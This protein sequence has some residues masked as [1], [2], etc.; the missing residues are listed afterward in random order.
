LHKWYNENDQIQKY[1]QYAYKISNWNLDFVATL[2]AEN[3]LRDP[4]R[5]AMIKSED[6]RWFCQLHRSWHKDVVDDP[7][8]WS[9]PY[10]Q[11]EQCWNKYKGWTKFYWYYQ[12]N[13]VK[14]RF[15]I[16]K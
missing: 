13:K 10:W 15:L 14:W 12:R 3:W 9:D 8:F 6:A 5:K 2:E 4:H 7:R 1:V 16:E 11:L